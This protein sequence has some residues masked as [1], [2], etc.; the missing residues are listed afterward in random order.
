MIDRIEQWIAG[1]AVARGSGPARLPSTPEQAAAG[2]EDL[3]VHDL[4]RCVGADLAFDYAGVSP[5]SRFGGIDFGCP[6]HSGHFGIATRRSASMRASGTPW[7]TLTGGPWRRRRPTLSFANGY[8]DPREICRA[9]W[10]PRSG[11]RGHE[12]GR[13][14]PT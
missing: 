12:F 8:H 4:R 9:C 1:D 2:H 13:S 6:H 5:E 14:G 7:K 10:R 11:G 3:V